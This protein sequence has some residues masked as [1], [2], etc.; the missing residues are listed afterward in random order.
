[1]R[2]FSVMLIAILAGR[3]HAQNNGFPYGKISLK[4]VTMPSFAADTSASA[5]ILNEFGEAYFDDI[6]KEMVFEYHALIKIL[7]AEGLKLGDVSIDLH[8]QDHRKEYLRSAKASSYNLEN[9]SMKET[10]LDQKSIHT[11]KVSEYGDQVKF[12]IPNVRVGSVIEISYATKSPFIFNFRNWEFQS[13]IPKIRSE[14]WATIPGNY[15]Y[16]ITLKGFLKLSKNENVLVKECFTSGGGATADCSRY[17]WVIDNVPAFIAEDYMTARSNFISMINFELSEIVYFDGRKD[18][19]TK[20]WKDAEAEL[21]SSDHFGQQLKRGK[22][23]V[24]GRIDIVLANETDPLVK[25]QKVYAFIQDWFAWDE[26]NGKYSELGIKKAFDERKGN[27]GDINLSLVAALRYAGIEADPMVLS[28]RANGLPTEIHPVLSDFN[29]VIAK[30]RIGDK[31][32]L[33]DA[34]DDFLPFGTIPVRCL[35]GKGR[36][37]A[38]RGSYWY[39]LKTPVRARRRSLLNMKLESNGIVRGSIE[40]VYT[41]YDAVDERKQIA[42]AGSHDNYFKQLKADHK[43]VE[44]TGYTID[45]PEDLSQPVKVSLEFEWSC[46]DNPQA[47]N[48]L[49]SPFVFDRISENPF[50]SNERMYPVDFGSSQERTIMMTFEYPQEYQPAELPAKVGIA[51]PNSTAKYLFDMKN[52]GNKIIMQSYLTIGKPVFTSDEYHFL[53]ELYAQIVAN[54]QTELLFKKKL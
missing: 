29:Y 4:D 25:A 40:R 15:L 49:F 32:F 19:V 24:D 9:G 38:E 1:M 44:L 23:I 36:V 53:K 27:V 28:T 48:F 22:S 20:E 18:R 51:L 13:E 17:K 6:D 26:R 8:R 34:T 50:R 42:S 2:L 37:F 21:R 10:P 52:E 41:G 39:D 33:L 54:H 7:K 5:V 47:L 11:V 16:N 30:A 3:V 31:D 45:N 46:F 14:Y 35:N 12:A 43:A